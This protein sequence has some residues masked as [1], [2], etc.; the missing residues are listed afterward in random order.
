MPDDGAA[1]ADLPRLIHRHYSPAIERHVV[2]SVDLGRCIAH[3]HFNVTGAVDRVLLAESS[4]AR[5][6][7]WST[8]QTAAGRQHRCCW[9]SSQMMMAV[10]ARF[11]NVPGCGDVRARCMAISQA[12][13]QADRQRQAA[14]EPAPDSE[15]RPPEPEPA[16]LF[17]AVDAGPDAA[18]SWEI[19]AAVLLL[20][21]RGGLPRFIA[22]DLNG[23]NAARCDL[24]RERAKSWDEVG[25][26]YDTRGPG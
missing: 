15:I 17:A 16:D 2:S 25:R 10:A 18:E 13:A 3:E 26:I 23:W 11:H 22:D 8:Y 4:L 14:A 7:V 19:N 12:L 20:T 1:Q 9:L 24:L 5:E 21:K 6:V